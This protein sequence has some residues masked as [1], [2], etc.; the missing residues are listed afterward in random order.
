[1]DGVQANSPIRL[2]GGVLAGRGQVGK[3]TGNLNSVV[4]PGFNGP[5]FQNWLSA[6]DVAFN[7][8]TTFRALVTSDDPDFE[9]NQLRVSG[10]VNLGNCRLDLRTLFV[11]PVGKS[12]VIIDNDGTDA[13]AGTFSGLP[14][15]TVF[16]APSP[17]LRWRI[18]YAGG[19]GNDVVLTLVSIDFQPIFT[20]INVT[21]PSPSFRTIRISATAVPHARYDLQTT[22]NLVNW[23]AFGAYLANPDGIINIIYSQSSSLPGQLYRL[24]LRP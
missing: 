15:G 4:Q 1:V 19:D 13:V 18:T 5:A 22:T 24:K 10:S 21:N 17:N 20:S 14:E 23:S 7:S 8:R 3:V 6:R 11:P 12:Y 2:D 9:N 16:G